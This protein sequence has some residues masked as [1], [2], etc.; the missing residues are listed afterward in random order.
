[1]KIEMKNWNM[2]QKCFSFVAQWNTFGDSIYSNNFVHVQH[3]L[4]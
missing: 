1:M 3:T 4:I 2:F